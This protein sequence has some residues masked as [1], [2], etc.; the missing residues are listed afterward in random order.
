MEKD[1]KDT[2]DVKAN[3]RVSTPCCAS[4]GRF[5][6]LP[7]FDALQKEDRIQKTAG[8]KVQKRR[9]QNPVVGIAENAGEFAKNGGV[10]NR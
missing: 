6:R 3:C 4:E 10:R 5:L 2:K 7:V 9:R 8:R 1:I